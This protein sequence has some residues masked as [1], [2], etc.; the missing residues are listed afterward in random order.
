MINTNASNWQQ[1]LVRRYV[2][3]I[4]EIN[5]LHDYLDK[6]DADF[7]NG[8]TSFEDCYWSDFNKLNM[9]ENELV[10]LL[11]EIHGESI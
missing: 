3:L 4:I 7:Y 8:G 5:E 6:A 10:N 1:S 11:K 2:K 9:L